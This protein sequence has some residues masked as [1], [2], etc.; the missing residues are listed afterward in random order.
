[1]AEDDRSPRPLVQA[2][3]LQP[4]PLGS[5]GVV[6]CNLRESPFRVAGHPKGA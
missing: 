6:G 2:S 5:E 3:V 1:M 4:A